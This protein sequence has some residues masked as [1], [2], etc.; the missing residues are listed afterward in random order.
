MFWLDV[1]PIGVQIVDTGLVGY[2]NP[3]PRSV[4]DVSGNTV[5]VSFGLVKALGTASTNVVLDFI[6]AIEPDAT[7]S[8]VVMSST[9][10][11]G[12]QSISMSSQTI[13]IKEDVSLYTYI[14]PN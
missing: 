8:S 10:T 5:T 7:D 2:L 6:Y 13:H 3:S 11:I 14:L 4:T 9:Q 12:G 1:I